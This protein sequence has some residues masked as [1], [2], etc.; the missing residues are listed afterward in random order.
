MTTK[1]PCTY[2]KKIT[3]RVVLLLRQ[4]DNFCINC[5]DEHQDVKNIYSLIRSKIQFQTKREKVHIPC[6]CLGLVKSYKGND[7]LQTKKYIKMNYLSYINQFFKSH[8]WDIASDQS[9][10]TPTTAMYSRVQDQ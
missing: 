8:G 3:G 6:E 7:L 10:L 1:D 9:D 4:F 2:I 5:T